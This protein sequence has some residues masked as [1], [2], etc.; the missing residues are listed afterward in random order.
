[1]EEWPCTNQAHSS[2]CGGK[3][4][5]NTTCPRCQE[6][7]RV[8]TILAA[9]SIPL[10]TIESP[11]MQSYMSVVKGTPALPRHPV[12]A[13]PASL[14]Q[15]PQVSAASGTTPP[16][17]PLA[18]STINQLMAKLLLTTQAVSSMLPADHPLRAV[19]LQ[20]VAVQSQATN[21]D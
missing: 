12:P 16:A 1:M 14:R 17:A 7:H 13:P 4:P 6:E 19:C 2:N 15:V 10:S 21:H 11:P 9:S 20:A 8:A 5:A 18:Q 3:H